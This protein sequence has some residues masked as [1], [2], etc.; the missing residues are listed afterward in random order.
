MLDGEWQC[1]Y[2]LAHEDEVLAALREVWEL[3]PNAATIHDLLDRLIPPP[4]PED[5]PQPLDGR[6][7]RVIRLMKGSSSPAAI[8]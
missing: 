3:Q 6:I 2:G 1:L 7:Q 8:R 4:R 5:R